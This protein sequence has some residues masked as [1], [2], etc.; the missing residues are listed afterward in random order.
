MA[1]FRGGT[2]LGAVAVTRPG[3][4]YFGDWD[5]EQLGDFADI[6]NRDLTVVTTLDTRLQAL[7]EAAIADAVIRE[8]GKMA[9]SQGAPLVMTSD[10][11]GRALV[12]GP[13]CNQRQC[14]C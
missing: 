3:A 9:V 6:G 2:P 1:A 8:G 7:D 12:G 11:A 4:R 5:A 13:G 10:G 14:K